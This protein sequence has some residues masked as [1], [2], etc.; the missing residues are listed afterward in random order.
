MARKRSRIFA[1]QSFLKFASVV[2]LR[3]RYGRRWLTRIILALLTAFFLAWGLI[4]VPAIPQVPQNQPDAQELVEKGRKLYN[5]GRYSEAVKVLQQAA[6]VSEMQKDSLEVAIALGNL[7][8]ALK[9]LGQWDKAEAALAQSLNVLKNSG[10]RTRESASVLAQIQET[11][12][13]VQLEL[14]KAE[15]ALDTWKQATKTYARLN[16][17]AGKIRTLINQSLAMQTLGLYRQARTTLEQVNQTLQKQ[18]DS[19]VQA[20]AL[21]SFGDVLKLV[22]DLEQSR[23][24]LQQSRDV[25][26]RL[27]SPPEI[28]AALLSLGNTEHALGRRS[29]SSVATSSL[30]QQNTTIGE[31]STP[32][33]CIIRPTFDIETQNLRR[34]RAKQTRNQRQR[35]AEESFI[36]ATSAASFHYQQAAQYYQEAATTSGSP[37]TQIQAQIN[38]LSVLLELQQWSQ[39]Q[40]LLPNLQSKLTKI[41]PSQTSIY[42]QI[43]LAQSLI[44]LKQATAANNPSWREIAQV[45]ATAIQQANNFGDK[46]SEAYAKGVLGGVYLKSED[47]SSQTLQTKSL[48]HAQELTK[49]A[50]TLA[51]SIQA[52]DIVY[53][54]QWQLGNILRIQGDI[55][56]AIGSYTQ[57]VSTLNSLRNDLA[58]LNPDVQFSF[59]DNVEPVYRQLVDLLLQ[60]SKQGNL[61][62]PSRASQKNL[63]QARE[64]LEALQL[65]E[66]EDFFREACLQAKPTQVDEI[67][68]KTDTTAAVIYPIILK[69]R[70]E[71]ILKLPT[72]NELRHYTTYKSQSEVENTLEKLQEY[73]REPDRI[74]DVKQLSQQVYGW[75]I[76]PL[77][78]EI[79]RVKAK[80]LVF[81]LDGSLRNIPMGVLYDEKQ[82]QYLV[83]KYAIALAPGLQL[84][85]P[86]PLQR[87]Q[88]N[89]LTGGVSERREVEGRVFAPLENVPLELQQI[90]STVPQ[91]K[92]LFNQTFTKTKLQASVNSATYSVVHIATHGEFSSN[93]EKTF[94]LTW[95]QLLKVKDFDTLL[96]LSN[97]SESK[98]IELLVLSACE[99][100]AGDKRAALGLAGV[101][102]RAGAR[103][104][105]ATLW[106][107]DDQSTAQLM[108]QFYQELENTTVTKA[109]ALRRAQLALLKTYEIPYFWAAYVLIGNW[110]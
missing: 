92:E 79:E 32:L 88:L 5:T 26:K 102:V 93:A 82:K 106:S 104:T 13:L 70:L 87:K 35:R 72:Q 27:Q 50:L 94:I 61:N 101:A 28:T 97:Q 9:K 3:R 86:K 67:V 1:V 14:G 33:S 54:W 42:A 80:T 10:L 81:V 21:R 56:G 64:V 108:S 19:L 55:E 41:P 62:S 85:D 91:S 60:D 39:V 77:E 34:R 51:Q 63:K 38:R 8:L 90:Q 103:S 109:E 31:K 49:Q 30:T 65:T 11:Q 6:S 37:T 84:V 105:V 4:W 57:A 100:A 29:Q 2:R 46:R 69:D 99:T 45:L 76:K 36:D 23:Q 107:V 12:G 74:N 44:C 7:S 98:S 16:D 20:I 24:V 66:L 25:A 95:E 96:R 53:L 89:A 47:V 15:Q 110:L 83:Q 43:N 75:L 22:G 18:P 58:A 40:N 71:I 59:R 48:D 78:A 17:G 68:D 52:A 73:L